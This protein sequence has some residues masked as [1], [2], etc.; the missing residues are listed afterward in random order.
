MKK[1]L[2]LVILLSALLYS[3]S[4]KAERLGG[5]GVIRFSLEPLEEKI[6]HLW[7]VP[8]KP[9]TFTCEGQGGEA[10]YFVYDS[11]GDRVAYDISMGVDCKITFTPSK[12]TIYYFKSINY[13]EESSQIIVRSD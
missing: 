3:D 12:S 8:D 6:H 9:V 4:S 5:P 11:K 7:L 10:D 1:I 13:D 2:C